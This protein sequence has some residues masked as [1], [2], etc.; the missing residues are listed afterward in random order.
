[1]YLKTHCNQAN[2]NIARQ[3]GNLLVITLV[4]IVVL[5]MLGLALVKILSASAQQ[6]VI[7][8]YGARAYMAAQSGLENA[9]TELFPLN[10]PA[11]NCAAV[12]TTPVFQA[13]YLENCAVT[14]SCKQYL[15]VPDSSNSAGTVSIFYLQST[16]ICAPI[17]CAAGAACRKDYWQTQRTL[18]VEAKTLP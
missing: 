1:M 16:A 7:E 3:K 14:L 8:Y 4:I 9:L 15:A 13:T 11:Q 18:S 2:Q 6:N 5:L 10:N 17:S 12:S